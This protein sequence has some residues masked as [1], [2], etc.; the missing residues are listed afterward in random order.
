MG[1]TTVVM[2]KSVATS[3]LQ[4]LIDNIEDRKIID[5]TSLVEIIKQANLKESDFLKYSQFNHGITESY[6]RN[7]VYEGANFSIYIMSWSTGDF[8]AIH[9]HGYCAWGAVYF[10]GDTSHRLYKASGNKIELVNKGVVPKGTIAPVTG[11]LVHAMGNDGQSPV[12]TLHVYGSDNG[13]S[14]AN[15]DS[16]VYE[17]EK[18]RISTTS[19]EAYLNLEP[20]RIKQT[21]SGISTNVETITDYFRILLPY[22]RKTQNQQTVKH[23]EDILRNPQLY[24]EANQSSE[25]PTLK[26][27][28]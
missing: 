19:G 18:K 8:T 25:N 1:N 17:L 11:N 10:F 24:F 20:E 9:S 7:K 13:T 14:N 15:D 5:N 3:A 26:T 21:V 28:I 16:L 22:Y 27:R 2:K 23:L 6:G 12:M 4:S